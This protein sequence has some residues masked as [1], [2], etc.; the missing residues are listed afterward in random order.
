MWKN[1]SN[2]P[3]EISVTMGKIVKV[4]DLVVKAMGSKNQISCE[5]KTAPIRRKIRTRYF[6]D[7]NLL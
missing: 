5:E 6:S 1:K 3:L 7:L 4:N 2:K